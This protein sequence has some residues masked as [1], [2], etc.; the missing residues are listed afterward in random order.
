[1]SSMP[2]H[3]RVHAVI[4]VLRKRDI[5]HR[6]RRTAQCKAGKLGVFHDADD[7]E[8][9]RVLR[10][11]EPEVLSERVFVFIEESPDEGFVYDSDRRGIL[12]IRAREF[13]A[14]HHLHAQHAEIIGADA[15]PGGAGVPSHLAGRM[16]GD[17]DEFAPV[18]DQGVVERE[19]RAPHT[20][21]LIEARF[22]LAIHRF[23]LRKSV[24]AGR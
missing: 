3:Q 19:S 7:P 17:H 15:V 22:H 6:P 10:I 11:V 5:K 23:E 13:A 2:R 4:N 20:G 9:A 16:S 8:R 24:G 21:D 12:V 18:I 1:M 14:A